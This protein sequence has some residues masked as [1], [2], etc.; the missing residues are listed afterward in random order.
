MTEKFSKP[1]IQDAKRTQ[2]AKYH[3]PVPG[4]TYS[5]CIKSQIQNKILKIAR[6]KK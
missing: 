6:G 1:Q 2:Q 3:N 5:S 4:H